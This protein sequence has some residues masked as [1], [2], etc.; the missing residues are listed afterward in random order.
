MKFERVGCRD[1]KVNIES[2]KINASCCPYCHVSLNGVTGASFDESGKKVFP[3]P[4]SPSICGSCA[5]ILIFRKK[6][7]QLY[8]AKPLDYEIKEWKSD[9]I[10]WNLLCTI[11]EKY[12]KPKQK[13]RLE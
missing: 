7:N 3:E 8:L 9:S 5:E 2:H 4:G 6:D 10:F 13:N 1:Q 11:K 12:E